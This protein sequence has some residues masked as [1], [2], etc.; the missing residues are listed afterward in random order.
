M[1]DATGDEREQEDQQDRER[2]EVGQ[3]VAGDTGDFASL[4]GHFYRA[5]MDRITAWRSRLDQTT[6]WAVIIMASVLTWVFSSENNPHYILLIGILTLLA[7]LL[8]EARRYQ[9]YDA[10]RS[11]VRMLQEDLFAEVSDPDELEHRDWRH[12]LGA[13][14][15]DPTLRIPY[16]KAISHRLRHVH[17]L[18]ITV[19]L[20]A[21]VFRVTVFAGDESWTTTA[22]I[23]DVSGVAVVGIVMAV[24]AVL[25]GLTVASGFVG[26]SER[27]FDESGD[28]KTVRP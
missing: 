3:A 8:I 15:R 5:E 28:R 1:T 4:I 26:G 9:K 23:A 22:A 19:L 10:W 11:R 18:L 14:L 25:L 24:Y 16:W 27:E 2:A 7:F 17:F 13:D 12:R 21:W 6:N 20:A